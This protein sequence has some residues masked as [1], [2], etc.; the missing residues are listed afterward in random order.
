ML[1]PG[2]GPKWRPRGGEAGRSDGRSLLS[3][4]LVGSSRRVSSR[5]VASR[6]WG[7]PGRQATLRVQSSAGSGGVSRPTNPHA[8]AMLCLEFARRPGVSPGK[9]RET[10]ESACFIGKRETTAP[11]ERTR[12]IGMAHLAH[13]APNAGGTLD[14]GGKKAEMSLPPT[15]WHGRGRHPCRRSAKTAA[16]AGPGGLQ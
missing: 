16:L 10:Q 3:S 6:R 8:Y 4:R 13:G 9:R 2:R 11:E 12:S 14:S 7:G 5:R 15:T 1:K